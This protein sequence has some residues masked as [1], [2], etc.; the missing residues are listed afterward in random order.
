MP[1]IKV[2]P[3]ESKIEVEEGANLRTSLLKNG[4]EIKSTCGGCASCGQ[5]VVVIKEGTDNISEVSFEEKQLIGNVFHITSERLSCQ[6]KVLGDITVDISRHLNQVKEKPKT[7]RR[8]K[9]EA[10]AVIQ[11]RKEKASER[12]AKQ[13]GFKRPKPFKDTKE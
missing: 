3:S 5:C 10:E 13:G 8:T 11:E 4:F 12:P 1:I 7:V 9:E 6:T 2:V